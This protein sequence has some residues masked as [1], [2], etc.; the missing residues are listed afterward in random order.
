MQFT[1][2]RIA[3]APDGKAVAAGV[4]ADVYLV[5][6]AAGKVLQHHLGRDLHRVAAVAFSP[7]GDMFA[8]C[9]IEDMVGGLCMLEGILSKHVYVWDATTGAE[10]LDIDG[11]EGDFSSIAF[12]PDGQTFATAHEEGPIRLWETATGKGLASRRTR[13]RR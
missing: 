5:D 6:V 8:S 2:D 13:A 4:G 9:E 1:P 7:D 3:F 12:S 10:L 11:R